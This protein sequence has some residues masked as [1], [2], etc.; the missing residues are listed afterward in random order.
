[1]LTEILLR[2]RFYEGL[3]DAALKRKL[4]R[5]V[6]EGK[7]VALNELKQE[8]LRWVHEEGPRE[9]AAFLRRQVVESTEMERLSDQVAKLSD[10]F[11]AM[12]AKLNRMSEAA[13]PPTSFRRRPQVC[14]ICQQPNHWAR[15]CPRG[16][17]NQQGGN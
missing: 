3:E 7:A 13:Q 6:R 17:R 2:D 9:G 16:R 4:K 11:K 8:A 5:M 15:N 14:F 12:D 10:A 1:M